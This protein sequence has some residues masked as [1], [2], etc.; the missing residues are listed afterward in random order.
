M[1]KHKLSVPEYSVLSQ[2]DQILAAAAE[3]ISIEERIEK[4]LEITQLI[5]EQQEDVDLLD[6]IRN[7]EGH[8]IIL[9]KSEM[10]PTITGEVRFTGKEFLVLNTNHSEELVNLNFVEI[11]DGLDQK[12]IF[13]INNSQVDTTLLWLK[14]LIDNNRSV[15]IWLSSGKSISG[16]IIR[17]NSDHLDVVANNKIRVIPMKSIVLLRSL[18]EA[19]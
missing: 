18:N 11:I 3:E 5:R 19:N 6:R 15:Q 10:F 12:A 7:T 9:L 4:R 16:Q 13:R 2:A 8:L 17:H 1:E 14:N